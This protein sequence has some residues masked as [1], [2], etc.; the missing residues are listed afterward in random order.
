MSAPGLTVFL[1]DDDE[2]ALKALETRTAR[3]VVS[4]RRSGS[5]SSRLGS[6]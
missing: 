3:F 1:I 5:G 2:G 4:D 6:R